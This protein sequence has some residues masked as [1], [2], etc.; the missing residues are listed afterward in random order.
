MFNSQNLNLIYL[1]DKLISYLGLENDNYTNT[2]L[3]TWLTISD[4]RIQLYNGSPSEEP[5]IR[6]KFV[7]D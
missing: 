6:S 1:K 3:M 2:A 7:E 5:K 4:H